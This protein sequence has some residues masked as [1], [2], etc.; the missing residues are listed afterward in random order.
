MRQLWVWN[1]GRVGKV[2]PRPLTQWWKLII[3]L[4]TT[5][6]SITTIADLQILH[7]CPLPWNL[8][9]YTFRLLHRRWNTTSP[10]RRS[11]WTKAQMMV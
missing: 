10:I 11:C 5:L 9:E 2:Y 1:G 6:V 7:A 8:P 3:G 4:L